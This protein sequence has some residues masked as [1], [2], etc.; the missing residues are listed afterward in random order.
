[1]VYCQLTDVG[2]PTRAKRV[3]GL[4]LLLFFGQI[5]RFCCQK[6]TLLSG[7]T[8]LS[9]KNFTEGHLMKFKWLLANVT[10]FGFPTRAESE[11]FGAI[12]EFFA[13]LPLLLPGGY[14][15]I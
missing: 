8:T 10:A 14:I 9:P 1:M 7:N 11:V 2:S 3:F 5:G 6:A 12:F 13:L 15:E 4:L